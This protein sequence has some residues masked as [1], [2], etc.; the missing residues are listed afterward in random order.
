MTNPG[1]GDAA[2]S[3]VA[4]QL[5]K[6]VL[7]YCVLALLRDGPRYGVELL[8]ELGRFPTLATSQ[9][10][11]YPLL[12]RLRRAGLADTFLRDSASGP[13]R[14]YYTLTDAGRAALQE[15]AVLWPAFRETVDHVL[16]PGENP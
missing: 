6:G 14:R 1:G 8:Q 15:F 12:S 4:T 2:D 7:E 3:A 11:I 10:T 5:R 9:G 13:S 16:D